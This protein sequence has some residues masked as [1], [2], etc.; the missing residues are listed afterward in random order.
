MN[1]AKMHVIKLNTY[2]DMSNRVDIILGGKF[3][4]L[5]F[6]ESSYWSNITLNYRI[7]IGTNFVLHV[8]DSKYQHDHMY[9]VYS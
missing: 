9:L 2:L 7:R 1:D 4:Q 6:L 8:D 3:I 5:L